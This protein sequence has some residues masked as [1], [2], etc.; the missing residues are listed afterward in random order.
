M[1]VLFVCLFVLF[2]FPS[3][4]FSFQVHCTTTERADELYKKQVGKL[5]VPPYS[6]GIPQKAISKEEKRKR[7]QKKKREIEREREEKGMEGEEVELPEDIQLALEEE[8]EYE[9]VEKDQP[10]GA[11]AAFDPG[12]LTKKLC[13]C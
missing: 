12:I 8:D 2:F 4:L 13:R 11:F 7:K 1:F 5:L 9:E 6:A 3:I 10:K